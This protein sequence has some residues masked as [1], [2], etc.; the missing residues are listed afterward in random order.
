MGSVEYEYSSGN[1]LE[2]RN[3]YFFTKFCG[4]AFL[5]AWQDKRNAS[6]GTQK[7]IVANDVDQSPVVQLLDEIQQKIINKEAG[8]TVAMQMLLHLCQRFEV[9]KRLHGEYGTDWRP[10]KQ[11]DYQKMERY[12]RFAEVLSIA[13]RTTD[14]LAFLNTMLKCMDTLTAMTERLNGNQKERLRTL[15]L[16]ERRYIKTLSQRL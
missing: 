1:L 13:Y 10:V 2:D 16:E 7:P 6:I 4:K 11:D 5:S 8:I 14:R 3:T 15:I 12:V 9:T